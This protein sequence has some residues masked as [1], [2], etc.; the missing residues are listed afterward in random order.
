M[1]TDTRTRMIRAAMELFSKLGY[2]STTTRA[3]A[4]KAGVNELTIFRNFGSKENLLS[5]VIDYYFDEKDMKEHIAFELTGELRPDLNKFIASMRE[6]LRNRRQLFRLVLREASVNEIVAGK[7]S[8]FPVLMKGFI[9]ARLSEIMKGKSRE[10][11]DI[12]T[13]G[14]FLASYFIRSEMMRIM[15]GT[16][17]FHEI[18][19]NRTKDVLEIFLNGFIKE[20]VRA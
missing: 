4:E 8:S 19:E 10:D 12:E 1:E 18:D 9:I 13:A 11:I 7:L 20:G 15:I 6:N 5:E 17:P 2:G 3:I 16:D 14:V